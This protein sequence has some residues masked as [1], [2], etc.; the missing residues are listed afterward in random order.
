MFWNTYILIFIW[1]IICKSITFKPLLAPNT[2]ASACLSLLERRVFGKIIRWY[3]AAILS[4]MYA[5]SVNVRTD[6][7]VCYAIEVD[8]PVKCFQGIFNEI[9][10][11]F[12]QSKYTLDWNEIIFLPLLSKKRTVNQS[13]KEGLD[14]LSHRTVHAFAHTKEAFVNPRRMVYKL[15][16]Y[17]IG[18]RRGNWGCKYGERF[19]NPG[20]FQGFF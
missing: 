10:N 1:M 7:I 11:R 17:M 9:V 19:A 8:R 18:L 15:Q 12:A 20:S 16:E 13:M 6:I 14:H 5:N 2:I 3:M 4:T